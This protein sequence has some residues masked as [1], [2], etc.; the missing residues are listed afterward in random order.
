MVIFLALLL[1]FGFLLNSVR[2]IYNKKEEAQKVMARME[3]EKTKLQE[4]EQFLKDSLDK[5]AT[6]EG[7]KFEIRKKLNVAEVGESVAIIVNEEQAPATQNLPISL[8]QKIKDFLVE[9]FK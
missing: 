1:V 2:K 4:R 9:L 3:E 8:W 7:L 5:L 6:A